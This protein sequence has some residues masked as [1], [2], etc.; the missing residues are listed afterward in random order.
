MNLINI[1][2][3]FIIN[4]ITYISIKVNNIYILNI[5]KLFGLDNNYT[6]LYASKNGQDDVLKWL[7][8]CGH[9]FKYDEKLIKWASYNDHI[10]ILKW[11]KKS[12]YKIKYDKGAINA[13]LFI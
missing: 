2:H 12:G 5:L 7:K 1:V 10:H 3:K 6:I 9:E 8:I 13:A 4:I 11:F